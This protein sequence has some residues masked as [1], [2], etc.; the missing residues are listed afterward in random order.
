M[1]TPTQT[2]PV[3]CYHAI[4]ARNT[5]DVSIYSARRNGGVID[6]AHF[7]A[8]V[9]LSSRRRLGRVLYAACQ[10]RCLDTVSTYGDYTGD[11]IVHWSLY[12]H[13]TPL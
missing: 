10:A 13:P 2:P 4:T 5:T 7:Y 12:T 3:T 8:N 1:Q 9:T 11:L 6:S